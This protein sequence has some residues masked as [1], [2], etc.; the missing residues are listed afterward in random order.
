MTQLFADNTMLFA[1][2][3]SVSTLFFSHR[4]EVHL[5]LLSPHQQNS[6]IEDWKH[7]EFLVCLSLWCPP[8]RYVSIVF[9]RSDIHWAQSA[10]S[11]PAAQMFI[12]SVRF[13]FRPWQGQRSTHEVCS[14]NICPGEE[15]GKPI[16]GE[17]GPPGK[18]YTLQ[19]DND[20][21]LMFFRTDS[22]P[23]ENYL[24]QTSQ[25]QASLFLFIL[26]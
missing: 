9:T 7:T 3:V 22:V 5:M 11:R 16:R 2:S 15:C 4:T 21:L 19:T 8:I 13:I 17:E 1:G 12:H 14:H 23:G 10:K 25:T 6:W 26:K 24:C 20:L 18:A